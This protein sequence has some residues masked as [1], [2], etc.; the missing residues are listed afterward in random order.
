MVPCSPSA[1]RKG[2][3]MHIGDRLNALPD[4]ATRARACLRLAEQARNAYQ[5]GKAREVEAVIY[6]GAHQFDAFGT[7][8]RKL[9]GERRWAASKR[10][11]DLAGDEILSP[12]TGRPAA[13]PDQLA[14]SGT[15]GV[16]LEI[17]RASCRERV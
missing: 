8:E 12:L 17:G 16:E 9:I 14:L 3:T 11:Q 15:E 4:N 1:G 10:A 6:S 13:L 2:E 7:R 5:D